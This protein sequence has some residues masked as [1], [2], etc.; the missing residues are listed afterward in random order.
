[1][2]WSLATLRVGSKKWALLANSSDGSRRTSVNDDFDVRHLSS[3]SLAF[4]RRAKKWLIAPV[5][6]ELAATKNVAKRRQKMF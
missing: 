1:M 6:I 3:A 5:K 4:A 2:V